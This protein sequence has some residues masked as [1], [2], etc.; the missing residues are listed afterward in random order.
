MFDFW[1]LRRSS[2]RSTSP[3]KKGLACVTIGYSGRMVCRPAAL[4]KDQEDKEDQDDDD[5]DE[6]KEDKEDED[7]DDDD[8]EEEF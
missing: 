4:L 6:D 5:D 2:L 8:E 1:P 3:C 7:D